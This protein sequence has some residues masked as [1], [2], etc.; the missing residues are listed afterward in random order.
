[1]MFCPDCHERPKHIERSGKLRP[2]CR[3]CKNRRDREKYAARRASV[4]GYAR[5]EFA[6]AAHGP[7][8]DVPIELRIELAGFA[9]ELGFGG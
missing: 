7:R 1:M 2:W 8:I 5:K 9:R 6:P 3:E 4:R